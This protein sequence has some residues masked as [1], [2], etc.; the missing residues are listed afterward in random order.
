MIPVWPPLWMHLTKADGTPVTDMSGASVPDVTTLA[1]GAYSFREPA[2]GPV[3]GQRR[4]GTD[5]VLPG[6]DRAGHVGRRSV[7]RLRRLLA[8]DG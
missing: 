7:E 3:H 2:V 1:A 5:R 4:V 6:P 8:R